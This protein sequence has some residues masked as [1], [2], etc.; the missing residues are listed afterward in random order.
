[1]NSPAHP[2]SP[3][4]RLERLLP[5]LLALTVSGCARNVRPSYAEQGLVNEAF[6]AGD[7]AKVKAFMATWGG[8]DRVRDI[9]NATQKG[10]ADAVRDMLSENP[11]LA[12]SEFIL[13][14]YSGGTPLHTAVARN[15]ANVVKTLLAGGADPMARNRSGV[16]PLHVAA[17]AGYV[18]IIRLLVS[19]GSNAS[20]PDPQGR[21]PL[22]FAAQ[23]QQPGSARALLK[24]GAK[25]NARD[26]NGNTPLMIAT[27]KSDAEMVKLLLQEGANPATGDL[28]GSTPLH[29]AARAGQKD[30]ALMLLDRGVDV[31]AKEKLLGW[32]PLFEAVNNNKPGTAMFLLSRGAKPNVRD[33]RGRTALT[34]AVDLG[35]DDIADLLRKSGA[36]K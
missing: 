1:L 24:K 25:V 35:Y 7:M 22:H 36:K 9:Q 23:A 15:H 3:A 5:L 4:R 19:S 6:R 30:I 33:K 13:D 12:N 18:D 26:D 17:T 2:F 34:D 16:T 32:T 20:P 31:N 11:E 28:T 27:A 21:T 8:P 29:L 14:D 10:D